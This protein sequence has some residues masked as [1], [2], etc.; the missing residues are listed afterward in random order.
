MRRHSILR[1]SSVAELFSNIL[2]IVESNSG[3]SY[4]IRD[5]LCSFPLNDLNND[6][7]PLFSS[8]ILFMPFFSFNRSSLCRFASLWY[9]L[10]SKKNS[11]N[12][13]SESIICTLLHVNFS[14][15]CPTQW[16]HLRRFAI[17]STSKFH[18]E[19]SWKLHRFWKANPRGNYDIDLT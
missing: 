13:D 6:A 2:T 11:C 8:Q 5:L 7:A 18:V 17:D 14:S 9:L 16:T 4:S 15:L 1:R 3:S 19:S 12:F 10:E